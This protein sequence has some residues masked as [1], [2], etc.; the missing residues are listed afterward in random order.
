MRHFAKRLALPGDISDMENLTMRSLI[1]TGA[2]S[3]AALMMG[4]GPEASSMAEN[5][6]VFAVET[7]AHSPGS[8]IKL[9]EQFTEPLVNPC[10]GEVIVFA[11]VAISQINQ[12]GDFH[13]EFETRAS[14]T[15]IGPESG[16]TYEYSVTGYEATNWGNGNELQGTFGAGANARMIS[17]LPELTFTA[18]FQFHGVALPSG[19]FTVTRNVDRVECKS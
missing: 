7:A 9:V 2:V 10:N 5:S 12:T 14:G 16:A 13:L 3:L 1:L 11:G 17:S 6:P 4:C 19:E 18:H 15:G 8:H